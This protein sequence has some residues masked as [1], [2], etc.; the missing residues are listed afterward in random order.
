MRGGEDTARDAGGR[1]AA[2]GGGPQPLGRKIERSGPWLDIHINPSPMGVGI[3]IQ[4]RVMRRAHETARS[5]LESETRFR[6]VVESLREGLI[7]TDLEDRIL[8]VNPRITDL[9]GRRP[10]ELTGKTAQ[11]L[12]FET[13]GW[14]EADSRLAARR[15]QTRMR[16]EAPLLDCDGNVHPAQ[17]IPSPA[18][19][20]DRAVP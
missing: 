17:V 4:N 12:L 7:I 8:Y 16:Y 1:K 3:T 15:N 20:A 14:K 5:V 2:R 13:K 18:R 19:T 9:T 6:S 11:D 10:E